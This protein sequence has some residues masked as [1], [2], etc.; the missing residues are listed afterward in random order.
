[1]YSGGP[2]GVPVTFPLGLSSVGVSTLRV[3]SRI[4]ALIA[5]FPAGVCNW[6]PLMLFLTSILYFSICLLFRSSGMW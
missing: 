2:N 1:M 4:R 5:S 3:S 6:E